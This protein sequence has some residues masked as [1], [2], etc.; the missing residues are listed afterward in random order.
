MRTLI[1]DTDTDRNRLGLGA[2]L[3]CTGLFALTMTSSR[4][5]GYIRECD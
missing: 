2:G 5:V 4:S 3:V 1:A